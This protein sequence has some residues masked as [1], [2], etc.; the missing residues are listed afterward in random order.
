SQL[1]VGDY[2]KKNEL[3]DAETAWDVH[4]EKIKSPMNGHIAAFAQKADAL[5]LADESDTS[6]QN[7]KEI[8]SI[9][10]SNKPSE[11]SKQNISTTLHHAVNCFV[12]PR[13]NLGSGQGQSVSIHKVSTFGRQ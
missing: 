5:K 6:V 3:I 4:S 9:I 12:W 2:L 10:A 13:Q 11:H 8:E 7:W 1:Y